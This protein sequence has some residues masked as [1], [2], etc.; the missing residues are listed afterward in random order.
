MSEKIEEKIE[1]KIQIFIKTLDGKT[2]KYNVSLVTTVKDIF[3]MIAEKEGVQS[4]QI[5]LTCDGKPLTSSSR[6]TIGTEEE[7]QNEALT[8]V[9]L[10]ITEGT[11]L[12]ANQRT[13]GGVE[14]DCLSSSGSILNSVNK[15]KLGGFSKEISTP[16]ETTLRSE[17]L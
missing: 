17:A 14:V 11:T 12:F 16:L 2:R 15:S 4:N 9:D 5:W 7:K 13:K 6:L 10:G 3:L 8:V 1:K